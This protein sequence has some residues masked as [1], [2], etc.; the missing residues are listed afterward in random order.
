M[1]LVFMSKTK[2]KTLKYEATDL[3]GENVIAVIALRR[4]LFAERKARPV[5]E[6]LLLAVDHFHK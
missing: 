3:A 4:A 1:K 2:G 6:E 5:T